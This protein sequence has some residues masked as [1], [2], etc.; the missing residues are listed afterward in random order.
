MTPNI[1]YNV[2]LIASQHLRVV[3]ETWYTIVQMRGSDNNRASAYALP[4]SSEILDL[5][6]VTLA[7][8]PKAVVPNALR[9]LNFPILFKN[10][11]PFQGKNRENYKTKLT[12]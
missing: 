1:F 10:P 11:K 7:P 4:V 5:Q 3:T 9:R 8:P 2:E 12:N 6:G